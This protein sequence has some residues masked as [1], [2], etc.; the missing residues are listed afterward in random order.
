M[1][2]L[3]RAPCTCA[4]TLGGC[5][6]M[7]PPV[8]PWRQAARAAARIGPSASP[9]RRGKPAATP[10][11]NRPAAPWPIGPPPIE[12]VAAKPTGTSEWRPIVQC[13]DLV[14]QPENAAAARAVS[15]N[16]ASGRLCRPRSLACDVVTGAGRS[17]SSGVLT[18]RAFALRCAYLIG[19][20]QL[21]TGGRGGGGSGGG[22]PSSRTTGP[23]RI[24]S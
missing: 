5:S 20:D 23:R 10:L 8:P 6:H 7:P 17:P 2:G 3:L 12:P 22:G 11:V 18:G 14:W 15:A 1:R 16:A 4:I 13:Q 19:W 9:Y 21:R 24:R